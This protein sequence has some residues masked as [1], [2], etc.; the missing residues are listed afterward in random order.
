[1]E[2]REL[3]ELEFEEV[4]LEEVE[5]EELELKER[6]LE[7]LELEELELEL[8]QSSRACQHKHLP[9]KH[10]CP[11]CNEYRRRHYQCSCRCFHLESNVTCSHL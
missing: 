3:E 7:E 1:M 4:E 8:K 2:E 6:E 11:S 9:R 5:L 10:R